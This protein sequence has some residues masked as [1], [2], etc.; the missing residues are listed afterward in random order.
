M[1]LII[2]Q[3]NGNTRGALLSGLVNS[4]Y[5]CSERY[6]SEYTHNKVSGWFTSTMAGVV[7]TVADR[8]AST[9]RSSS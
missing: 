7:M 1:Q 2:E 4:V 3:L 6:I 9:T 5:G 8:E